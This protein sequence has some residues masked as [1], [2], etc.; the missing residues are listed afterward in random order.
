MDPAQPK[1]RIRV[2]LLRRRY[3]I[4][5]PNAAVLE[6]HD[7]LHPLVSAPTAALPRALL[8]D[9]TMITPEAASATMFTDGESVPST[10]GEFFHRF[11]TDITDV[12]RM[13]IAGF[14]LEESSSSRT[15]S[16]G[17]ANNALREQGTRVTNP[18]ESLRRNLAL[19][20]VFKFGGREFR[21]S[22]PGA[23]EHL[24]TLLV[25]AASLD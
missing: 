17:G 18:S 23:I 20:R 2:D 14:Y 10:F 11:R 24:R 22:R 15:F 25:E 8:A 13:L 21:L 5:G 7:R 9:S 4:S 1:V 16:T 3:E 6:W 12:D 19:R